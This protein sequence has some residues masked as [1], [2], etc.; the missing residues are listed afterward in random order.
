M[1]KQDALKTQIEDLCNSMPELQGVLLASSDGL[2]IAHSLAN[3][4]DPARIAAMAVAAAN[5][6]SRVSDTIS[7][8]AM[9]EVNIRASDGDIF[10]YAAGE[11]AVLAVI[12]PKGAN[13]GLIHIEA[14][15][16]AEEIA[17]LL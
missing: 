17:G 1:S 5:L 2:P 10:V 15:G 9:T 3:G 8:G 7:T 11:K 4:G 16:A 12:G 13:A 14:H 6:G